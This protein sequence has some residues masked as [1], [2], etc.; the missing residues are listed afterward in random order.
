M[1]R[2]MDLVRQILLAIE[3]DGTPELRRAPDVE[4][5]SPQQVTH[6]IALL[7][8]AGLISAIDASSTSGKA[9]IQIGLTWDG[10]EF[11]DDIRDPEIWRQTKA[12]AAKVGSFS[13]GLF[14]DLAKAA[15]V[16]KAQSLGFPI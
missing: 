8:Q 12:G 11:L 14:A 13:F 5:Y 16:A 6:H 7:S 3:R 2:D 15:V 1:K 10:H 4:G 9:Y